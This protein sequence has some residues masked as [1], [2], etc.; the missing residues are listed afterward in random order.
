MA[1]DRLVA[2]TYDKEYIDTF[3]KGIDK[4]LENVLDTN[5]ITSNIVIVGETSDEGRRIAKGVALG[6]YGNDAF[7]GFYIDTDKYANIGTD[8]AGGDVSISYTDNKAGVKKRA[9]VKD[10]ID[11][12]NNMGS[13][14]DTSVFNT[15]VKEIE[16][17]IDTKQDKT[18]NTLTTNDKTVVGAINS[19]KTE[20][21]AKDATIPTDISYNNG[22][23]LLH[24]TTEITAQENKVKLK[25]VGGQSLIGEGDIS[26]TIS[27]ATKTA[28]GG[29]KA[30]SIK[31]YEEEE[32]TIDVKI[33]KNN[34]LRYSNR[35]IF[36]KVN[37]Y[38]F[39][40]YNVSFY[41]DE[42]AQDYVFYQTEAAT[43]Q[44]M[45]ILPIIGLENHATETIATREWTKKDLELNPT[46]PANQT[47]T[48]LTAI[49]RGDTY[50]SIPTGGGNGGGVATIQPASATTLGGVKIQA[51]SSIGIDANGSIDLKFTPEG[52]IT[53][54]SNGTITGRP[55]SSTW[56]FVRANTATAEDTQEVRIDGQGFL[57]TKPATI[58]LAT[59]TA[60]G[61][62]KADL[63]DA[64]FIYPAAI[65]T[66][67]KLFVRKQAYL[68]TVTFRSLND[69][70]IKPASMFTISLVLPFQSRLSSIPNLLVKL[71]AVAFTQPFNG[72]K[73]FCCPCHVW[74]E[75]R[76]VTTLKSLTIFFHES[77]N[78]IYLD[79]DSINLDLY[80]ITE[81]VK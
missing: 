42:T 13:K 15:K 17:K 34:F 70:D 79:S 60:V 65:S 14:L 23:T 33:D 53:K 55:A 39:P 75:M 58:A 35:P 57:K 41:Y 50:Y 3:V 40:L 68:H 45:L 64:N 7:I 25:T 27:A 30:D 66:D 2:E 22:F 24:D 6:K 67:G 43:G 54:N 47:L 69:K 72:N 29:I 38:Y 32:Y 56:G 61:G 81:E 12:T 21:D 76:S 16:S 37:S 78:S 62:I 44:K 11:A 73:Y 52:G 5:I 46:V 74:N 51:D 9:W 59:A 80:I 19:L 63:A 48:S 31:D 4:K 20:L 36:R 8:T 28:L 1:D 71:K 49:K 18:D 10:V 26:S 77:G